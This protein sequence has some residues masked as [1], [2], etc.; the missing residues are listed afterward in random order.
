MPP[1][2]KHLPG[3]QEE[4]VF[5]NNYAQRTPGG[6]VKKHI[7]SSFPRRL[8]FIG[9]YFC[10]HYVFF[11]AQQLDKGINRKDEGRMMRRTI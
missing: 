10:S 9:I 5:F 8:H 2:S 4:Y 7:L 11:S 1:I 3:S 6:E